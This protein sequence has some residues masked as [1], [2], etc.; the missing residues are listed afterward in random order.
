VYVVDFVRAQS[1][2][3]VPVDVASAGSESGPAIL[4][5]RI[6]RA[7]RLKRSIDVVGAW[8]AIVVVA[9]PALLVAALIK[10]TSRGP[11]LYRQKRVGVDG[12]EFELLK[13]RTMRDGTHEEVLNDRAQHAAYVERDFKLPADDPRI[14]RVGQLLRKLSVDEIPQ[15]LNVLSGDMSLV[16]IRPLLR[17]ELELRSRHDQVLYVSMRPGITGLWQVEGRS[18]LVPPQRLEL[19]RTYVQHWSNRSDLK[20]LLRTPCAVLRTRHT[21]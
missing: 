11:V 8:L 3:E 21:Q 16:G 6:A 9:L 10:L 13:F 18:S 5:R 12:G 2:G 17:D 20:I 7:H 4:P 15:L 1:W 14:T 19:D